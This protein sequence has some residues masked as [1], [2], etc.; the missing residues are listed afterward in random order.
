MK[1]GMPP[2]H[3]GIVLK[4]MYLE[5]LELSV[6]EF[7]DKV[8]VARKTVSQIINE[9][10]GISAEMALRLSAALN[11]TPEMWLD[12]QQKYDLWQAEKNVKL[13]KIKH[14]IVRTRHLPAATIAGAA[15]S[16]KIIDGTK[17][18]GIAVTKTAAARKATS[19]RDVTKQ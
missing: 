8:G 19:K 15:E 10:S 17:S 16:G 12:M 11:T 9:H 13:T 18:K 6:T 2:V 4:E 7:A 1:R 5:P 3:P 14:L